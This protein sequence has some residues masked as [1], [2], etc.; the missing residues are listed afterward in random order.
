MSQ[1]PCTLFWPRSGFTP[2][3]A[4]A[5]IAGRHGEVGDRHHRGRAL[6]VLGDAEAVIDRA[7]CR[8]WRRAAP[9]ARI[10]SAGTPV[11]CLDRL[12][13]SC[14][15]R[16]RRRAQSWNSSQSQRSRTKASLTRPS[17]TMTCASA[18]STATLVPGLQRQVIVR[19]DMRRAHQV[20]AARIDD[21]QLGALRAAASSCARRTPDGRRSGWRRSP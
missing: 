20:D 14:A 4:P 2:T 3:P 17:V 10:G 13:A 21:D 18:V 8:R 5:D 15:A 6:A 11:I 19:L 12:G 7:R 1:E 9:R 16:R